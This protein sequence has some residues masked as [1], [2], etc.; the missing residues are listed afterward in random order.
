MGLYGSPYNYVIHV[1]IIA[2]LGV[3]LIT[4]FQPPLGCCDSIP[5]N[6]PSPIFLIPSFVGHK[7]QL[8]RKLVS[9]MFYTGELEKEIREQPQR[10]VEWNFVQD[11]DTEKYLH[12]IIEEQT[13][14][15]YFHTQAPSCPT[16]GT[17]CAQ[18]NSKFDDNSQHSSLCHHYSNRMAANSMT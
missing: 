17:D 4:S 10:L 16:R 15:L 14:H 5:V 1:A 12:K 8:T 7:P 9:D 6:P 13:K 18:Q 3:P 2:T 11:S